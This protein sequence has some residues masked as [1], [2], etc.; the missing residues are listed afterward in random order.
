M[1]Y[2]FQKIC[3]VIMEVSIT[4]LDKVGLEVQGEEASPEFSKRAVTTGMYILQQSG[5]KVTKRSSVKRQWSR[6][7]WDGQESPR[8]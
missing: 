2:A 5:Y 1:P 3:T 7:V 8:S 4:N 6:T